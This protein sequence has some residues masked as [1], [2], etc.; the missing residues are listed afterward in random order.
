M[1]APQLL[2]AFPMLPRP[3][4]RLVGIVHDLGELLMFAG[5]NETGLGAKMG[6]PSA[7]F[8]DFAAADVAGHGRLRGRQLDRSKDAWAVR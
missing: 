6:P 7:H 5:T 2:R 3:P 1:L 8:G 4:P